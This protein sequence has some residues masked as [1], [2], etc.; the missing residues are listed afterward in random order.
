M[1]F[2]V[3]FHYTAGTPGEDNRI[4]VNLKVIIVLF[5]GQEFKAACPNFIQVLSLAENSPSRIDKSKIVGVDAIKHAHVAVLDCLVSL[6]FDFDDFFFN[7]AFL[8]VRCGP[9]PESHGGQRNG[10]KYEQEN[11]F[12]RNLTP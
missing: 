5:E 1:D 10:Q 6:V 4:P 7:I 11:L 12:H 3:I 8:L 2:P 9:L